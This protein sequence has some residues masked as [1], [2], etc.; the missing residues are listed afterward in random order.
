MFAGV[1]QGRRMLV[2]GHPGFKGSWLC[3]W[4]VELG[5]QVAGFSVNMPTIPSNFAAIQLKEQ[6]TDYVGDIRDLTVLQAAME[7]FNPEIIFHLAAQS[8]VRRSYAEPL[9]TFETNAMGRLNVLE[10]M[11]QRPQVRVGVIITSDKC[12]RNQ[13]WTW[14]YR[15]KDVLGGID[16]YSSSKACAENIF[17]AYSRS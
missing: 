10:C 16:P 12:Y 13:E 3:A 5:A 11:R 14:G 9:L 15:E 1:Y 2:T 4:L 17:T 8:L 6:L 7:A